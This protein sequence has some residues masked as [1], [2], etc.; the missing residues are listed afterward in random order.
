MALLW[1][2]NMM[3]M[4]AGQFIPINLGQ[5]AGSYGVP[6]DRTF[7]VSL[8]SFTNAASRPMF[9]LLSDYFLLKFN[10][11]RTGPSFFASFTQFCRISVA[12]FGTI[13]DRV[14]GGHSAHAS[15]YSGTY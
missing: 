6:Q 1:V 4:G 9:G 13:L 12:D 7:Y 8:F 2:T 3:V 11:P 14:A 5:I 10:F 15:T